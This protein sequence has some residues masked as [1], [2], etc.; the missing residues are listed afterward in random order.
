MLNNIINYSHI[1]KITIESIV[2]ITRQIKRM[3]DGIESV[4]R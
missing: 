3:T 4:G 1:P 2:S